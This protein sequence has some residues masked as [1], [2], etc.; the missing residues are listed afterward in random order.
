[1]KSFTIKEKSFIARLAAQKLRS[2]NVAIV[3]GNRIH[4]H[5]VSKEDFLNNEKWL[6]HELKHI[7]QYERLG[8]VRF[9]ATYLWQTLKV[10]YYNCGLECEAR[11]A[12]SD[13]EI[14]GRF[15][16]SDKSTGSSTVAP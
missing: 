8:L 6:R 1:V 3:L 5:G 10:G 9:I 11:E 15:Y 4:L 16:L 7:E 14:A 13:E 2:S 12:E